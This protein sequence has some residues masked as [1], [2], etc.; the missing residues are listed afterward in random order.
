MSEN[1]DIQIIY[2]SIYLVSKIDANPLI[3]KWFITEISPMADIWNTSSKKCILWARDIKPMFV[4]SI[5]YISFQDMQSFYWV[6]FSVINHYHIKGLHLF[7]D[8]FEW[9]SLQISDAKYYFLSSRRHCDRGLI[10][11]IIYYFQ[12]WKKKNTI[13]LVVELSAVTVASSI[14]RIYLSIYLS[15]YLYDYKL[16]CLHH[17]E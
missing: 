13:L 10:I 2:L 14:L 11:V 3:W 1:N 5:H 7:W 12:I 8:C 4:F 6:L 15:I 16:F 17:N 9:F